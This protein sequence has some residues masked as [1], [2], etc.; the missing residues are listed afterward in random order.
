MEHRFVDWANLQFDGTRVAE[1]LR[2][3]NLVPFEARRPHVHGEHAIGALPA[4]ENAGGRFKSERVLAA[5]LGHEI[6]DAA[7]AVSAGTRFRAVIVIDANE[8]VGARRAR[9]IK[10]HQLIIRRPARPRCRACFVRLY[11]AAA[12]A[13][14]DDDD[15]VAD[16]VHLHE[17]LIGECAHIVLCPRFAR[18]IWRINEDWPEAM[19]ECAPMLANRRTAANDGEP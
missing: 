13:Q 3:W 19:L 15:L 16:A 5:L 14:I 1:F 7:H 6:G 12:R 4:I 18:F 10:R 17:G 11:F 2:Q 8:S 9:R